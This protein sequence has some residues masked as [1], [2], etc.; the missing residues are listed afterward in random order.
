ML[1]DQ[2]YFGEDKEKDTTEITIM[3]CEAAQACS[4][5]N[6]VPVFGISIIDQ[7]VQGLIT[8]TTKMATVVYICIQLSRR[9]AW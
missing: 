9:I 3:A 4:F 5:V 7:R 8:E 1:L 2:W 6:V